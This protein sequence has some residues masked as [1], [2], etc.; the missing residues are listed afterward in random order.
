MFFVESHHF[1]QKVQHFHQKS[2]NHELFLTN[3]KPLVPPNTCPEMKELSYVVHEKV[4]T[5]KFFSKKQYFHQKSLNQEYF[6]T[7]LKYQVPPNT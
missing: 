7:N 4:S 3:L 2:L 1:S 6:L 5:T